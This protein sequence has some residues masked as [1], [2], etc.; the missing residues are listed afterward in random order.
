V[1]EA[2]FGILSM[3]SELSLE[4]QGTAI[5]VVKPPLYKLENLSASAPTVHDS[6]LWEYLERMGVKLK[7]I[8]FREY[9]RQ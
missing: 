4:T 9:T 2:T 7:A 6:A 3:D 8:E 5:H 1:I